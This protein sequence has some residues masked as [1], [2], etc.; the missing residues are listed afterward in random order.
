VAAPVIE[1][2]LALGGQFVLLGS[3]D[4]STEQ[5]MASLELA[6][7]GRASVRLQFDGRYA[8]RIYAGADA[9]LIPSRYE[10]CGLTQMIAMRYGAIPIARRTGGLA[11]TVVDAGEPRGNGILF[12]ELSP[13][14]VAHALER[15]IAVYADPG[16]WEA[17]Q[18]RG[19]GTDF[20]WAR[21]AAEYAAIYERARTIRMS[22]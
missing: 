1:R 5:A 6:F 4:A 10:P 2:W 7:P 17:L 15:A 19:L 3:G 16:R 21:S 11:D 12:D 22:G 14:S 13:L 18:R 20:S 9:L 8:H